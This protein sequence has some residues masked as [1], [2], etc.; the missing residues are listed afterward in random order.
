MIKTKLIAA[1][2]TMT[3]PLT[4]VYSFELEYTECVYELSKKY[5]GLKINY[6]LIVDKKVVDDLMLSN[7]IQKVTTDV[8]EEMEGIKAAVVFGMELEETKSIIKVSDILDE[9]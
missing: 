5:E 4:S 3:I 6:D 1:L 8:P 2:T 7:L 9:K